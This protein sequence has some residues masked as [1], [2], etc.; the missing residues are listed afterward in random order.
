[1]REKSEQK[2]DPRNKIREWFVGLPLEERIAILTWVDKCW[3]RTMRAVISQSKELEFSSDLTS[4]FSFNSSSLKSGDG[5]TSSGF[6]SLGLCSVSSNR[7]STKCDHEI[8]I[9]EKTVNLLHAQLNRVSDNTDLIRSLLDK[10]R[11]KSNQNPAV[12]DPGQPLLD[13]LKSSYTGPFL[14][15][16]KQP[17]FDDMDV[18]DFTMLTY[19]EVTHDLLSSER[20]IPHSLIQKAGWGD[21]PPPWPGSDGCG[22]NL[23]R[24][25]VLHT[26]P[27]R[28][29]GPRPAALPPDPLHAPPR[30]P[31]DH[32]ADRAD[33]R[34]PHS[35][36]ARDHGSAH[37]HHGPA[38]DPIRDHGSDRVGP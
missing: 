6:G 31:A 37:R 11:A 9:D 36:S 35:R 34:L 2:I 1:M 38:R 29:R 15:D 5:P 7:N 30:C 13:S 3:V 22:P 12:L 26:L 18:R 33:A 24:L 21:N 16:Q 20:R 8:G 25:P 4:V 27:R 14:I 23:R 19:H 17:A 10:I 32:H 28:C